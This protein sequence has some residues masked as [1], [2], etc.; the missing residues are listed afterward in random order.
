MPATEA[1]AELRRNAGTQFDPA[2]IEALF[3]VLTAQEA[4]CADDV[5]DDYAPS[6]TL[7]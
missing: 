2:V 4:S 1:R 3:E 7:N 5:L 6:S